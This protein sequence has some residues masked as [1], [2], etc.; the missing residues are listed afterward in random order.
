MDYLS[1]GEP[2]H[3]RETLANIFHAH[4]SAIPEVDPYQSY[5]DFQK[6]WEDLMTLI[7][8]RRDE[9]RKVVFGD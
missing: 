1:K 2:E 5:L 6:K 9:V 7:D 4:V 8:D 3:A